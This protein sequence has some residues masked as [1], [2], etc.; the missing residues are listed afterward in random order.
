MYD[1]PSELLLFSAL[2]PAQ[3]T[4]DAIGAAVDLVNVDGPAVAVAHVG[5]LVPGAT[6]SIRIDDSP[7]GT[8]WASRANFPT[9]AVGETV[10]LLRFERRHRYARA[11]ITPSDPGSGAN[12]GV[13]LGGFRK[14][15]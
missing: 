5:G 3:Y 7:D 13:M 6:A 4:E 15:I 2:P 12:V 10:T 8:T 14:L 1:L 11:A 9:L